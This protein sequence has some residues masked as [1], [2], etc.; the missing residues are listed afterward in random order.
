MRRILL[1]LVLLLSVASMA[2][3]IAVGNIYRLGITVH[4]LRALDDDTTGYSAR[5]NS[6]F[7]VLRKLENGDYIIQ[8]NKIYKSKK[9]ENVN[10]V[11][12]DEAYILPA[13]IKNVIDASDVSR[14]SLTGLSAGP[15]VVPFKYRF[16]NDSITGDAV[17]GLYAGITFEPGCITDNW[18]FRIT[19]LISAGI[20]QVSVNT[21]TNNEN[22]SSATWAAGFL[23]TDWADMNL[24]LIYGEDRIGDKDWE[25]EGEGWLSFMIGWKL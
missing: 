4:E 3:E 17:I 10:W 20:A 21:D 11:L 15:L 8:F 23:I 18:C 14:I 1:A 25:H 6:K 22:K 16:N 24:G 19:P 7:I 5:M 2:E 13:K 9:I 12:S